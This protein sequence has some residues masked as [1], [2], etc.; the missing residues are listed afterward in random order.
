MQT[1][2]DWCL[3]YQ[4]GLAEVWGKKSRFDDPASRDYLHPG[5]RVV[6]DQMPTGIVSW[7]ATPKESSRLL[8]GVAL[9]EAQFKNTEY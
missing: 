5:Q 4:D 7:P 6:S 8:L 9:T 2:N 1:Q 3:L